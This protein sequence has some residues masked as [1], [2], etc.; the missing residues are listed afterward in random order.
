[1]EHSGQMVGYA[2][3]EQDFQVSGEVVLWHP[4]RAIRVKLWWP[5]VAGLVVGLRPAL[6]HESDHAAESLLRLGDAATGHLPHMECF[7]A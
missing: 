4:S 3:G 7:R 1:M 5:A 6:A 2:Q